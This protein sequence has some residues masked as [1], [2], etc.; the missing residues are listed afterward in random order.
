MIDMKRV[1]PAV[2]G[3]GMLAAVVAG[4]AANPPAPTVDRVGFPKDYASTM[5]VLY[6]YDRPDNKSVRTIFASDPVFTVTTSTQN[7]YPYGSILVMETWR[8][9]QDAN[10]VPIQ[11]AN[12]RFQKDPAAT[13]T[14]VVMRKEKGFGEA[15]GPNRNGEWEYVAYHPD[16]TYQTPPENS[17]S[18]A[19]CHLQATQWK[20]WVF[21]AGLHFDSASGSV[22]GAVMKDYTFLPG[23]MHVKGGNTITF[24]NTDVIAHR[25]TD[26]DPTGF[27]TQDIPAGSSATLKFPN[28]AFTWTY[29]CS[30]HPSMKG[31]IV[32]DPQ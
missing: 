4:T 8:S 14:V 19:I 16:G 7:D 29:H 28:V 5:K 21:R 24:Y 3:L 25:I 9:L 13:P 18:C 12:G 15:Y 31:S 2:S 20:D 26:D 30:I 6:R 10:G 23:T 22:P 1:L 27:T 11:D 17:F 32:V